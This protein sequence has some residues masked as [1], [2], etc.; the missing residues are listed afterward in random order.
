MDNITF[1]PLASADESFLWEMLYLA[2]FV[3][4]GSP[5]LPRDSIHSPELRR[6][7]QGWGKPND[8]GFLAQD[9]NVPVGAVWIR[10]LTAKN[11]GYGYVDDQTPELS[12]AV[13]PEYRGMGIG[14]GLML[15][16]FSSLKSHYAAVCLSV[17]VENPASRLYLNMGFY[18]AGDDGSSLKM[19][20][21]L[22]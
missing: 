4:E 5:P 7:V 14:E 9:G 8:E 22:H 18:V 2:L 10:L 15:R 13:L 11:R 12:I 1:R 6:Y 19:I 20:K 3:P 17:S 21:Q 16:L